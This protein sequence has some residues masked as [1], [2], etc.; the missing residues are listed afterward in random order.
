V[1]V[2][3]NSGVGIHYE[4]T[5]DGP[6]LVLMHG[7]TRLGADWVDCGYVAK[8]KATH[9]VI[10]IDARGHGKSDKPHEAD[11][12]G[13]QDRV[14]DVVAV[15][16]DLGLD[17]ATYWGYSMGGRTGFAMA[18]F[19]PERLSAII[20]GGV[21]PIEPGF[22]AFKDIDGSDI[23]EFVAMLERFISE[24]IPPER[25]P[26]LARNDTRA[27]T[28]L[29]QAPLDDFGPAFNALTIPKFLYVGDVD[30]RIDRVKELAASNPDADF[31]SF[32]GLN[33]AA[34]FLRSDLVLPEVTKFLNQHSCLAE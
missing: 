23:T 4:V 31:V 6:A 3:D 18:E 22:D 1:P 2:A 5:G 24:K 14:A 29:M 8:L 10:T 11:A 21:T 27:L 34:G 25:I 7:F 20:I 30:D 13:L 26:D 32:P 15:L 33:H 12:Y 9:Q 17:K 28:A 16:D 19:A